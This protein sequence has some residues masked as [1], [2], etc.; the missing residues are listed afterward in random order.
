MS[1][2]DEQR[3]AEL[4]KRPP[5]V[6][7]GGASAKA[8]KEVRTVL[9]VMAMMRREEQDGTCQGAGEGD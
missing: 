4:A 5:R 1:E 7:R 9:E 8:L 2:L 6:V 3:I